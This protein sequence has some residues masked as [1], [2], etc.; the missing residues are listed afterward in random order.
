MRP[1]V[2]ELEK[3][4]PLPSCDSVLRD[5]LGDQVGRYEQLIT[6]IESPVTDDEAKILVNLFSSDDCFGLDW[7]LVTLVESAPSW[8]IPEC[9]ENTSNQWIR[10]LRQRLRN[11][12]LPY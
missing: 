8:P 9:L 12:G 11:S 10:L 6:R 3:L 7:T 5:N 4:G 1:E 2:I